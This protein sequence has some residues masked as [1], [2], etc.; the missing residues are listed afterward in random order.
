[1]QLTVPVAARSKMW[2]R[3]RSLA[4]IVGSNHTGGLDVCPV[5]VVCCRV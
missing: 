4:E 1:M 3:G 5:G 2:V